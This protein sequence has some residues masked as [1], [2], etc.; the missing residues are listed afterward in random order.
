[1]GSCGMYDMS[2]KVGENIW[3]QSLSMNLTIVGI[4][5]TPLVLK[6]FHTPFFSS[7]SSFAELDTKVVNVGLEWKSSRGAF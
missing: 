2:D 7:C 4:Q 3:L 5:G 1:M 6:Y